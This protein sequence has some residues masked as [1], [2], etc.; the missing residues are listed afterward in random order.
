MQFTASVHRCFCDEPQVSCMGDIIACDLVWDD[1]LAADLQWISDSYKQL[2]SWW[3]DRYVRNML[4]GNLF[5]SFIAQLFLAP[6][7]STHTTAEQLRLVAFVTHM[8]KK[9]VGLTQILA[10]S[11]VTAGQ[12]SEG[13]NR[14][15]IRCTACCVCSLLCHWQYR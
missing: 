3:S 9:I 4:A 6:N 7:Y 2:S 12:R 14:N 13:Q 11:K 10:A 15:S 5:V 8:Q 1:W